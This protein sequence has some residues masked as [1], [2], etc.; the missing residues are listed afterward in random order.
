MRLIVDDLL[1]LASADAGEVPIRRAP[2]YL[3]ELVAE[4][5]RAVRTLAAARDIT[6]TVELPEEAP[7]VGDE[8]LLHRLV[9]NL[10]DN[11]IKHSSAGA[12]VALRL[13]VHGGGYRLEVADTGPGIPGELQPRIFEHFVRAGA[14]RPY[15]ASSTSG[16]GLGLSIARWIAEAHGGRLELLRSTAEGSAFVLTLPA[17]P[18]AA[19]NRR[20]D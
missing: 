13:S 7:F 17:E 15:S 14:A 9:L 12:S 18:S 16:A 3:E 10:L 19:E 1:M 6:V 5:A 8:A 20:T 11:A 2:L 4:C